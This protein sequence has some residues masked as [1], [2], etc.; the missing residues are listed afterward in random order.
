MSEKLG[1]VTAIRENQ[2]DPGYYNIV[3]WCSTTWSVVDK[4]YG[5]EDMHAEEIRII[6]LPACSCEVSESTGMLLELYQTYLL[7]YLD[8]IRSDMKTDD[9]YKTLNQLCDGIQPKPG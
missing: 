1:E 4:I 8:E 3:R 9:H 7:N 6:G 2:D 5:G